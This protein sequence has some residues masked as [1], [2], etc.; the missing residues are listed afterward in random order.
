MKYG[1]KDGHLSEQNISPDI[2]IWEFNEEFD[3]INRTIYIG[4]VGALR[5][6]KTRIRGARLKG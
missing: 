3:E 2:S 1:T 5:C 4:G 6:E